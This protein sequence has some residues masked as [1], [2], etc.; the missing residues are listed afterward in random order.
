M[1]VAHVLPALTK[2]G[3]EKVAAELANHASRAGHQVVLIA[4]WPVDPGLLRETLLPDIRVFYVSKQSKSRTGRYLKLIVWFW[5]HTDL[6]SKQDVI[7]CH[8]SYGVVFGFL[9][10][11]WQSVTRIEGPAIVQTNHSAGAPVSDLRRVVQ[12]FFARQC[13]AL[14]L[15][16]EDEYWSLFAK[17][18]PRII[19]RV[20]FNGIS[21]P[22]HSIVDPL[23]R[24]AYRREVGIPDNCKLVVGAIGRLTADREPW[25]YLPIFEEIARD[26]GE[27]V[28]FLLAGGGSELEAMRALAIEKGLAG[29]VHFPGEVNDPTLPLA[30]MDLYISI[31]VGAITGLAGMEAA[32]SGLPVIAMQWTPGYYAAPED[33]IWS[34]TNQSEVAQRS[35]ELLKSP[36]S[37]DALAQRQKSFVQ[38]NHTID[39]MASSYY[40][41]YNSAIARL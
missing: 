5:R 31:N 8:L 18:H 14:A 15:I 41:M 13:N 39:T 28:H 16:A 37:R 7:H 38:S 4:G 34:S 23:D 27:D 1:K 9:V 32:L 19:T 24:D 36:S 6:L 20:I 10:K 33:W 35:C 11:L 26:F 22:N 25:T 29:Q 40:D 12:S 17:K 21:Q 2:G 30:V 3:G